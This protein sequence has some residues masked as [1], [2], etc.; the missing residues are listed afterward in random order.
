[1]VIKPTLLK[2]LRNLK[3]LSLN[4]LLYGYVKRNPQIYIPRKEHSRRSHQILPTTNFVFSYVRYPSNLFSVRVLTKQKRL[5]LS[6]K[7]FTKVG[8]LTKQNQKKIIKPWLFYRFQKSHD[9]FRPIKV[10]DD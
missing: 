1:M 8:Y 7:N 3:N 10:F 4:P 6:N 5:F 2:W 9:L